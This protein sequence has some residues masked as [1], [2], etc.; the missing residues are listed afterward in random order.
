MKHLNESDFEILKNSRGLSK[1]DKLNSTNRSTNTFLKRIE[2]SL[3]TSAGVNGAIYALPALKIKNIHFRANIQNDD[4][5]LSTKVSDKYGYRYVSESVVYECA[6]E[7]FYKEVYSKFRDARGHFY[8]IKS[9]FKECDNWKTNLLL[10]NRLLIWNSPILYLI[11]LL[12]LNE[13]SNSIAIFIAL[14]SMIIAI[15]RPLKIIIAFTAFFG[16]W[17]GCIKGQLLT[18]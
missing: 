17:Y 12:L 2:M 14:I 8:S 9:L 13:F 15:I 10:I 7:S 18:W 4:F 5:Y 11:S 3:D 16:F 1:F 6:P